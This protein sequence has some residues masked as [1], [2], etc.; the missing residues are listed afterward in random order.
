MKERVVN[1]DDFRKENKKRERKE[2][3]QRKINNTLQWIE[4]NKELLTVVIPAGVVTI[5]GGIKVANGISRNVRLHQEKIDKERRI[6][7][8]S[9]G[10]H[11][12]LKRALKDNDMRMILE[13]RENGEK[14]SNILMDMNLIK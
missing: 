12:Y 13:R 9:L 1:I 4:D 2:A 6:Y 8:R 10:K 7:D 14:L 3:F 11:I 5:K